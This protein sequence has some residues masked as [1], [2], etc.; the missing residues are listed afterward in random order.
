M[1]GAI[2]DKTWRKVKVDIVERINK[3]KKERD[4]I[5]L[6]H[7]YQRPEIQ[8]LADV[9]G[10]SF[11][12]SRKARDTSAKVILFCGVHFMGESAK[13]LSPEKTVLLPVMNAGCPMADMVTAEKVNELRKKHPD[14]AVMTY[15]NSSAEVKAASDICC[16]SSN[17]VRIAKALPND[18]IIFVPDQ[19]L[20]GYVA[21]MVPEK[22]FIIY[23]GFCP[24]HHAVSEKNVQAARKEYPNVKMLV[25]PECPAVVA[26]LADFVGSTSQILDY[27]R[28]SDENEFIIG[29]E[30]GILHMLTKQNPTKSF[31][32]LKEDFS[33]K[34]MKLATINDVLSALE[35]MENTVELS[36]DTID[37]ALSS[38]DKML[39]I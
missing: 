4:A 15:I 2:I 30:H 37:R 11:D 6:A 9:V 14:A 25:H 12:L 32:M 34:D 28:E 8:D 23:N 7:Y 5:I 26:D 38:L 19:N 17:A 18:E 39:S 36:Q 20:G 31:H 10:D 33:C 22:K 21:K 3:L 27:A 29:T 24:V 35:T 1:K 16:T 13:I